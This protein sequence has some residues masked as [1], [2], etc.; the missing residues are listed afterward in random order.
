MIVIEQDKKNKKQNELTFGSIRILGTQKC[1]GICGAALRFWLVGGRMGVW[2][3]LFFGLL[4][5]F[6]GVWPFE[7]RGPPRSEENPVNWDVLAKGDAMVLRQNETRSQKDDTRSTN[8]IYMSGWA[9]HGWSMKG[10]K[11]NGSTDIILPTVYKITAGLHMREMISR[12]MRIEWLVREIQ[13]MSTK[14]AFLIWF[15]FIWFYFRALIWF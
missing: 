2:A 13:L 12:Y 7:S 4:A 10:R 8:A 14:H 11:Q 5:L 1:S 9:V 6:V 15:Y 3:L